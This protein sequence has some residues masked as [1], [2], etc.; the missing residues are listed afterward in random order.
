MA[1]M[2]PTRFRPRKGDL[3]NKRWAERGST[4]YSPEAKADLAKSGISLAAAR[5]LGIKMFSPDEVHSAV[6]VLAPGLGLPCHD[7]YGEPDDAY[8]RIKILAANPEHKY[9]QRAKTH[10]RLGFAPVRG[11]PQAWVKALPDTSQRIYITEGEKKGYKAGQEKL[12][13]I[14][15]GGVTATVAHYGGDDQPSVIFCRRFRAL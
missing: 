13:C 12:L 8:W 1:M 14:Y 2:K 7:P 9:K 15:L 10:Y 4:T 5:E 3:F 6:G 11:D